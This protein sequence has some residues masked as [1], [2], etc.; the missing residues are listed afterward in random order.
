MAN[1]K[2]G[3]A[4]GAKWQNRR[5]PGVRLR[6]RRRGGRVTGIAARYTDPDTGRVRQE[7]LDVT[8]MTAA[9]DWAARKAREIEKRAAEIA[10][11]AVAATDAT[12]EDG[13]GL[14]L[15]D[16]RADGLR[17]ASM[18]SYT[19]SCARIVAWA[20]E[21]GPARLR[22]LNRAHLRSLVRF[23]SK[24]VGSSGRKRNT[25][26]VNHAR[27]AAKVTLNWWRR[28]GMTP[29]LSSD[30]IADVVR[31]RRGDR[32]EPSPLSGEDVGRVLRAAMRHDAERWAMTRQEKAAGVRGT[33]PR[34]APIAPVIVLVVLSGMRIGEALALRWE[35]V[36]LDA[37]DGTGERVGMFTVKGATSKVRRDRVVSLR[38]SPALRA[39]LSALRLRSGG[40][41]LVLGGSEPRPKS[42]VD[43]ARRRVV[44]RFGAPAFS[45]QRLRQTAATVYTTSPRVFAAASA[46]MSA[47]MLGH[48]VQVAER[49]YARPM[50][51]LDPEATT[52]EA[53]LRIER[54][55]ALVVRQVAGESVELPEETAEVA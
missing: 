50:F 30:D 33:M 40:E 15:E 39:L 17:P 37:R 8:T 38:V 54:E 49:S 55:C 20:E 7:A 34:F 13:A 46:Y 14:F 19:A 16:R 18:R 11:G 23:L 27:R 1:G 9:R 31:Q 2:R 51:G 4:D 10:A 25:Q 3:T 53:A 41:G 5:H 26:T 35:D 42:G 43:M 45:W 36:D 48:S 24:P 12:V 44:D 22:D 52:G 28:E 6:K 21:H 29:L 47:R 32:V